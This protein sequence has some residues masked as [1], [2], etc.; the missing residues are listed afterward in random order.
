MSPYVP[1]GQR[2]TRVTVQGPASDPVP[3]GDG[4][5]TQTWITLN[6]PTWMVRIDPATAR[7]LE[8][9]SHDTIIAGRTLIVTGPYHPGITTHTRLLLGSRVLSVA[10]VDVADA[11]PSQLVLFC[12]EE[13]EPRS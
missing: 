6:P 7:E 5:F 8:R 10:G 9:Y 1:A 12:V 11:L 3:D 13:V 4:G 2:T